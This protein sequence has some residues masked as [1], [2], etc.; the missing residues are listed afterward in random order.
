V[1]PAGSLEICVDAKLVAARTM[2][3]VQV[4]KMHEIPEGEMTH[5]EV[6]GREMAK[7]ASISD[8]NC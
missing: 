5:Y 6:E 4:A 2:S 3:F 1:L 7:S 8:F